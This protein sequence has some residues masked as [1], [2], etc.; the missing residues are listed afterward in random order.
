MCVCNKGEHVPTYICVVFV[1]V[2]SP[3]DSFPFVFRP[4][5]FPAMRAP[6]VT[7]LSLTVH[8]HKKRQKVDMQPEDD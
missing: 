1:P 8:T 7:V 5:L 2:R 6:G 3:A 4:S